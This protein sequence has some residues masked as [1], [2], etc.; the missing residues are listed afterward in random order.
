MVFAPDV[1]RYGWWGAVPAG[2]DGG[3]YFCDPPER[4]LINAWLNAPDD[5]ECL[6]RADGATMRLFGIDLD[7]AAHLKTHGN[8]TIAEVEVSA[9]AHVAVN[10]LDAG[11]WEEFL[12]DRPVRFKTHD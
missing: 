11:V 4:F 2:F 12:P 9:D 8:R 10:G 1:R 7:L 3:S 6:A 5:P